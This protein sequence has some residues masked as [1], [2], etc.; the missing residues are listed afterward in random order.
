MEPIYSD[1]RQ[2]AGDHCRMTIFTVYK[3]SL[4]Q[5]LLDVGVKYASRISTVPHSQPSA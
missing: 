1:V 4:D 3:A 2:Q 5:Q